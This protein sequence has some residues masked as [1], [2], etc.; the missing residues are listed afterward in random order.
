MINAY[1]GNCRGCGEFVIAGAGSAFK[2]RWQK[3]WSIY[4][5]KCVTNYLPLFDENRDREEYARERLQEIVEA[6]RKVK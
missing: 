2:E 4:C 5:F 6:N 1:A 3:R